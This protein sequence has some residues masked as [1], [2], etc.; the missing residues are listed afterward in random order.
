M[1]K[2][3]GI[4][5]QIESKSA[6]KFSLCFIKLNNER[7]LLKLFCQSFIEGMEPRHRG[8]RCVSVCRKITVQRVYYKMNRFLLILIIIFLVSGML[9]FLCE[10]GWRLRMY[11]LHRQAKCFLIARHVANDVWLLYLFD[12]YRKPAES[13]WLGRGFGCKTL[14]MH[15]YLIWF[16]F[17][18][19]LLSSPLWQHQAVKVCARK[20]I[21][22][23]LYVLCVMC[24]LM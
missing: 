6:V 10:G 5:Q 15:T 19:F 18:F 8:S 7:H 24:Y 14:A 11:C 3:S 13:A 12:L 17:F 21:C 4:Y 20:P 2:W 1:Y 23:L 9:P 22:T 16:F